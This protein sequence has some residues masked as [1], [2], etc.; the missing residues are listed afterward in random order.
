MGEYN[1]TSEENDNIAFLL[2]SPWMLSFSPH[3]ST[4]HFEKE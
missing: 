2:T 3:S 4:A 1:V